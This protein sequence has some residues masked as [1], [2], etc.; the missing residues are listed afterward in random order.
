MSSCAD[1]GCRRLASPAHPLYP[2][3]LTPTCLALSYDDGDGDDMI[4]MLSWLSCHHCRQMPLPSLPA[5]Q[6]RMVPVDGPPP[7]HHSTQQ[8]RHYHININTTPVTTA[9]RQQRQQCKG[10]A[11]MTSPLQCH[12]CTAMTMTTCRHCPLCTPA[13]I[14][15][16]RTTLAPPAHIRLPR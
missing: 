14:L 6:V 4:T 3:S 8:W 1:S 2:L 9:L 11:S 15:A 12:H 10:A 13:D 5:Q 16:H 7:F